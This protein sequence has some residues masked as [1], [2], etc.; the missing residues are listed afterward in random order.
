MYLF[1]TFPE[2]GWF[3]SPLLDY[4]CVLWSNEKI[5]FNSH[6]SINKTA[7]TYNFGMIKMVVLAFGFKLQHFFYLHSIFTQ[8]ILV[9][10]EINIFGKML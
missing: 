8:D 3:N 1:L 10:A 4:R 2:Y 9:A 7:I 6:Y 5:T